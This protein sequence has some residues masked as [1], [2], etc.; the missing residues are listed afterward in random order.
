[1]RMVS[2]RVCV[3]VARTALQQALLVLKQLH[4]EALVRVRAAAELLHARNGR[5]W[6]DPRCRHEVRGDD[7]CTPADPLNAVYEHPRVRV[8]ER[9][10][11]PGGRPREV[12]RELDEWVVLDGDLEPLERLVWGKVG[13][14]GGRGECDV[15][16]HHTEDVRDPEGGEDVWGLGGGEVAEEHVLG[17]LC[18]RLR[19]EGRGP[20]G[21][22]V[23][24]ED[25]ARELRERGAE[26]KLRHR[27]VQYLTS[28]AWRERWQRGREKSEGGKGEGRG[29]TDHI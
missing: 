20:R 1:M 11:Y 6:G 25:R 8:A 27:H 12:G 15:P 29:C 4:P 22:R 5:D 7:G 19:L 17:D 3:V 2:V 13:E 24:I 16:I 26:R 10:R 28:R 21:G 23:V 14:Q 18:G 9:V